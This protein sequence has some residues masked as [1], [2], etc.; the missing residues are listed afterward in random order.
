MGPFGLGLNMPP[1]WT[2]VDMDSIVYHKSV[3]HI[4]RYVV[5][6]F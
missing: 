1:E 3:L 6:I 4:L 5:L 2:G